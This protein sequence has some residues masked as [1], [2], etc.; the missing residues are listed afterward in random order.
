MRKRLS[1]LLV[2]CMLFCMT[3]VAEESGNASRI[4]VGHFTFIEPE[5]T[6][7]IDHTELAAGLERRVFSSASGEFMIFTIDYATTMLS[8]DMFDNNPDLCN[9][10]YGLML[11]GADIESTYAF[12]TSSL[13]DTHTDGMPNGGNLLAMELN[14]QCTVFSH[15]YRG[16]GFITV[17]LYD[18]AKHDD[19][20]AA[21]KSMA[22]SFRLDGVSTEQML[23][24]AEAAPKA[25]EVAE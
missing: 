18:A 22:T 8:L 2:L 24:D 19:A 25:A 11:M 4:R 5:G 7:L 16:H 9:L 13:I 15:Y 21:A 10:T 1:L 3:A 20:C 14:N 23:A 17:A 12:F 6:S